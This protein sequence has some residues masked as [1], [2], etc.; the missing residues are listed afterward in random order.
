MLLLIAYS[1]VNVKTSVETVSV[2]QVMALQFTDIVC[3]AST[4]FSRVMSI[5]IFLQMRSWDLKSGTL[6]GAGQ[7]CLRQG[8]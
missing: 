1:E 3:N 8:F 6:L 5:I 4:A 2:I 7:L